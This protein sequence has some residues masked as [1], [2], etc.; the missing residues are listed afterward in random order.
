L[1]FSPEYGLRSYIYILFHL[2]LGKVSGT[3]YS[4]VHQILGLSSST[5]AAN[6]KLSEF[7]GIRL[8]L[9]LICAFCELR[10]VRSVS[11]KFGDRV[12]TLM[13]FFMSISTG[14]FHCSVR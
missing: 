7:Y 9:G 5:L 13:L 10:L 12:G 3:T 14:M 8:F 6:V 4:F 2:V 1:A 11:A